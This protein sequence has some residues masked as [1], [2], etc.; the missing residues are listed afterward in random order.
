MPV[1]TRS[2]NSSIP[3]PSQLTF[4]ETVTPTTYAQDRDSA[5]ELQSLDLAQLQQ[6]RSSMDAAPQD[7]Q[8][9]KRRRGPAHRR[10]SQG[11]IPRPPN[12][13]MLFRQHYVKLQHTPGTTF[14]DG[15][16]EQSLSKAIGVVWRELSPAEKAEWSKKAMIEK[17]IH[18]KNYPDYRYKPVHKKRKRGDDPSQEE[19]KPK[20]AKKRP[21]EDMSRRQSLTKLAMV[22]YEK[23]RDFQ[24]KRNRYLTKQLKLG[25]KHEE[26]GPMMKKYDEYYLKRLT[27]GQEFGSPTASEDG[28]FDDDTGFQSDAATLLDHEEAAW[29]L[30][31][32]LDHPS[33]SDTSRISSPA[34]LPYSLSASPAVDGL[35]L[36]TIPSL[37]SLAPSA[38]A[39]Q[40]SLS[41]GWG[42]QHLRRSSSVPPPT[43]SWHVSTQPSYDFSLPESSF[44][45]VSGSTPVTPADTMVS[46]TDYLPMDMDFD[47][48]QMSTEHRVL[49]GGRRASSAGGTRRSWGTVNRFAASSSN[50]TLDWNANPV[51]SQWTQ[52]QWGWLP[53]GNADAGA[54]C[55][56]LPEVEG[57]LF[58]ANFDLSA[59]SPPH[60]MGSPIDSVSPLDAP[61][62]TTVEPHSTLLY[63]PGHIP[64]M[65]PQPISPVPLQGFEPSSYAPS[66][67]PI[68]PIM[69]TDFV[70][71]LVYPPEVVDR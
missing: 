26:L 12:A 8:P 24:L 59:S 23:Q 50:Y 20:L 3:T 69:N 66:M 4:A 51:S 2:T 46:H 53:S 57:G 31:L 5:D 43:A 10:V 54:G 52:S 35:S 21:T 27:E 64:I 70:D 41:S 11:H 56:E 34:N 55:E 40:S 58:A 68:M 16:Q 1:T 14:H 32:K 19:T 36:P 71:A 28:Y 25:Y 47:Y 37:A 7:S 17:E 44:P 6:L 29:G 65:A 48:N 42:F 38:P 22:D 9:K 63:G 45:Q 67:Q 60:E 30:T 33:P 18:K 62:P 61:A 15:L 49:L 39:S 13:F